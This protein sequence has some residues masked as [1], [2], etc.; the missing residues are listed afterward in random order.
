MVTPQIALMFTLSAG[1]TTTDALQSEAGVSSA[2]GRRRRAQVSGVAEV[3]AIDPVAT[4]ADP[5]DG[6]ASS[7]SAGWVAARVEL[8]PRVQLGGF[9]VQS[10]AV[11][12]MVEP[13]AVDAS[14]PSV[15][16]GHGVFVE[17]LCGGWEADRWAVRGGKINPAFGTL[18]EPGRGLSSE[19]FAAD[20]ELTEMWGGEIAWRPVDGHGLTVSAFTADTSLLAR[21]FGAEREPTRGRDGGPANTGAPTSVVLTWDAQGWLLGLDHHAAVAYLDAVDPAERQVGLTMGWGRT[22]TVGSALEVDARAEAVVFNR[23]S[24]ARARTDL[25]FNASAQVCWAGWGLATVAHGLRSP[26]GENV[27]DHFWEASVGSLLPGGL[28][29][30]AGWHGAEIE[31]SFEHRL[32]AFARWSFELGV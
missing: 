24:A 5:P 6:S 27:V 8:T 19:R 15:F 28:T 32:G 14:Q 30:E 20:Y 21:S 11:F 26:G 12:E 29:L 10:T 16:Q 13:P 22:F 3:G 2:R 7:S 1:G 9:F 18:W 31:G 23:P 25:Q 17:E 4:E